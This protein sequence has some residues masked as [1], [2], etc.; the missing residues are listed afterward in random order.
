MCQQFLCCTVLIPALRHKS[1]GW[2]CQFYYKDK[3]ASIFSRQMEAHYPSNTFRNT[4]GYK[5]GEH[6]SGYSP[7]LVGEY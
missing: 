3:Y 6:L 7:V 1:Q 4:R 2:F 5:N